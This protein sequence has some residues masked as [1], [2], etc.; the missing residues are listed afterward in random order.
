MY[1][2]EF[3][4][5][6]KRKTEGCEDLW[7]LADRVSPV[8]HESEAALSVPTVCESDRQPTSRFFGE[9]ASPDHYGVGSDDD[10]RAGVVPGTQAA[11]CLIRSGSHQHKTRG[12]IGPSHDRHPGL[13]GKA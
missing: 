4:T 1:V 8:E 2:A 5:P 12:F 6:H 11:C 7:V 13:T 3:Q 10:P 9:A